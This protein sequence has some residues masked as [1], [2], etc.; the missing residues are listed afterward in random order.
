MSHLAVETLP[1]WYSCPDCEVSWHGTDPKCWVCGRD[2]SVLGGA[3]LTRDAARLTELPG[4]PRPPGDGS[5]RRRTPERHD[6]TV[7]G[8]RPDHAHLQR[9]GR[10]GRCQGFRARTV[11]RR[12]RC[13]VGGVRWLSER[14][15]RRSVRVR[16]NSRGSPRTRCASDATRTSWLHQIGRSTLPVSCAGAAAPHPLCRDPPEPCV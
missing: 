11:R 14:D 3:R 4:S 2:R 12:T 9:S 1:R 16:E 6:L 5:A 7:D 13:M 8:P 15:A 10:L